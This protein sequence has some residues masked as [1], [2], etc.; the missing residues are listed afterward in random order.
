M[1]LIANNF[2]GSV[3][4]VKYRVQVQ[5]GNFIVTVFFKVFNSS[6]NLWET[7]RIFIESIKYNYSDTLKK[8][9]KRVEKEFKIILLK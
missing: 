4:G 8:L 3:N 6:L 2:I 9:L 5:S 1:K 7:K